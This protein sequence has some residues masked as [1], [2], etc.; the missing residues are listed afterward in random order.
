MVKVWGFH[1]M[2]K[3]FSYVQIFETE[4]SKQ[5]GQNLLD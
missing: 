3:F 1:F 5:M 2:Q 4:F